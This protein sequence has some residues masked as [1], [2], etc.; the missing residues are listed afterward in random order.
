LAAS[1][2]DTV[3]A[4]AKILEE[5]WNVLHLITNDGGP[6]VLQES[7][8]IGPNACDHVRVFQQ[9]IGGVR[10]ELPKE[11]GLPRAARSGHQERGELSRGFQER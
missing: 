11:R 8:R 3:D 9:M 1:S 6:Y 7:A 2:W 10:K 4:C 5:F